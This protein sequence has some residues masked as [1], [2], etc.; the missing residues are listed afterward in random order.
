MFIIA[1]SAY[2]GQAEITTQQSE[3]VENIAI[4]NE[5]KIARNFVISSKETW[6]YTSALPK[7]N[8]TI[9]QEMKKEMFKISSKAV[10]GAL[11]RK[12]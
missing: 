6:G 10:L 12:K 5:F 1:Q 3:L 2:T 7:R 8:P 4:N 11:N 9:S